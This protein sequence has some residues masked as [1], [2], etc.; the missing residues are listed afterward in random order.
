M[1]TYYKANLG[2]GREKDIHIKSAH[3][4]G[5]K[6]INADSESRELSYGLEWILS[7]KRFYKALKILKFNSEADLFASN[8]NHQFY[9]CFSYKADPKAKAVGSFTI[10]WQSLKFC[11][12]PP[13][14]VISRKLKK[15]KA[16]RAELGF[17]CCLRC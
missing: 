15:I 3:M 16:E 13:F 6:N 4:R 10:S 5:H 11:A 1:P 8:I 2:M 9:N 7:L 12:F 17:Q 14:S